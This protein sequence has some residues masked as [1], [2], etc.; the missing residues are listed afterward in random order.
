MKASEGKIGRVF[1][2][3][4]EDGD[5]VPEC[6]EGFAAEKGIKTGHVVLIGGIGSGRVVVGPKESDAMPPEPVTLPVEGAHEVE[7]VGIIA[8]DQEG[9]PRLHIHA[10][11]GR[12]GKT[13]TGCLRPG[14][15]TWLTGEAVIY[16]ITGARA[17]RLLDAKSGFELMEV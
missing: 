2:L 13:L 16:E 3:K 15:K 17:Q 9:K 6:I 12:G 14:V 7:G 10:S 8:P 5:M 4:L 11:L 1:I